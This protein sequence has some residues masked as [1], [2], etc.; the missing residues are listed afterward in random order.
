MFPN[1]G[2]LRLVLEREVCAIEDVWSGFSVPRSGRARGTGTV[3]FCAA[4]QTETATCIAG[5]RLGPVV[6]GIPAARELPRHDRRHRRLARPPAVRRNRRL[7]GLAR[8]P[9]IDFDYPPSIPIDETRPSLDA[10][11]G[12]LGGRA[13]PAITLRHLGAAGLFTLAAGPWLAWLSPG[14]LERLPVDIGRFRYCS[15]FIA[16][17]SAED[18]PP[19]RTLAQ[20]VR[21]VALG[22]QK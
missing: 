19:S 15:G 14:L 5:S 13:S 9:W 21:D 7:G 11:L 18:L 20:A 3:S 1:D 6:A 22:R 16:R 2:G 12:Q 10:I 8:Y 17:R 4:W